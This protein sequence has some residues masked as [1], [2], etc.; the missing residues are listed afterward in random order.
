MAAEPSVLTPEV[1]ITAVALAVTIALWVVDRVWIRRGK[2]TYR[3]HLDAP[4]DITP[5]AAD[6]FELEVLDHGRPVE[7]ATIAM[8]RI[9][10]QGAGHVDERDI[11]A[12]SSSRSRSARSST[13]ASSTPRRCRSRPWWPGTASNAP[14]TA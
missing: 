11:I 14:R 13:S 12:R 1:V 5:G 3:V 6:E 9:R 7:G 10:N 2:V 4:V 8:V